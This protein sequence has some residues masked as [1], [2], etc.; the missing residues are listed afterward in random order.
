MA[1]LPTTKAARDCHASTSVLPLPGYRVPCRGDAS[2]RTP[3]MESS[4]SS[5]LRAR[6]AIIE[7]EEDALKEKLTGSLLA[8]A[9]RSIL[10]R[11]D[12][13]V[14]PVLNLPSEIISHF[15]MHYIDSVPEIG[16]VT[17]RSS[18]LPLAGVCSAWRS[19]ALSVRRLWAALK[20]HWD[21]DS[22]TSR[23]K[24]LQ[25]WLARAGSLPLDLELSGPSL[26]PS[27]FRLIFQYATQFRTLKFG[28]GLVRRP[29][30]EITGCF[31]TL[32]NLTVD[33]YGAGDECVTWFN[34]AH[35]LR[36]ACI[37]GGGVSHIMLP[38]IQL[39]ALDLVAVDESLDIL[40]QTPNLQ[41][42][43]FSTSSSVRRPPTPHILSS[44]H[45]LKVHSHSVG[46]HA[47]LDH[48]TLPALRTLEI[49]HGPRI[50]QLRSLVSRSACSLQVIDLGDR[51]V[52]EAIECLTLSPSLEDVTISFG[53][54]WTDRRFGELYEYPQF[55]VT[56]YWPTLSRFLMETGHVPN[57]R[58][59]SI[60]GFPGPVQAE[61][62]ASMLVARS[63]PSRVTNLESFRL[64]FSE[65]AH[66]C[67]ES[68]ISMLLA[69]IDQGLK[70]QI[71]WATNPSSNINPETVSRIH[72]PT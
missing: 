36:E 42:L 37:T 62:L 14:Y 40:T 1:G 43:A 54:W 69:L 19:V 47:L 57:L 22:A 67:N 50:S 39:T 28:E 52:D 33:L 18:P 71:E 34:D 49:G 68:Y 70:I 27:F 23:A 29:H 4:S 21:E 56:Q 66:S 17:S 13:V 9:R 64:E 30:E 12:A 44:L 20:I 11:L 59:L 53:R 16:K 10:R 55:D 63:E 48:L 58:A 2:V 51:T 38:W 35:Q 8:E 31:A 5:E 24:L 32:R 3:A 46:S 45:T 25:C 15:F 41:I 72:G 61:S 65:S 7:E 6:L 60:H 26:T